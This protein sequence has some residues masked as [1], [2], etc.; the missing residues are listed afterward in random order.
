MLLQNPFLIV[1]DRCQVESERF[2]CFDV[3]LSEEIARICPTRLWIRRRSFPKK[4]KM[5]PRNK[6][7]P[8]SSLQKEQRPPDQTIPE[9]PQVIL[10]EEGKSY[11]RKHDYF[12]L[13]AAPEPVPY[14]PIQAST[15]IYAIRYSPDGCKQSA[16]P[17]KNFSETAATTAKESP[18][19]WIPITNNEASV[20]EMFSQSN[21]ALPPEREGT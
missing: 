8:A 13:G 17:K 7:P 20:N 16:M 1:E 15:H 5:R 2:F 18:P 14:T 9:P 19:F 12:G 6:K 4:R 21:M 11:Q 10:L 3:A